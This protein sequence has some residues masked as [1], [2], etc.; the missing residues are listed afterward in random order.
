MN[1]RIGIA[2]SGGGHRATA[3]CLGSLMYLVDSRQNKYVQTIASVSGGSITNAYIALLN[4]PFDKLTKSDFRRYSASFAC[5]IAGSPALWYM[6]IVLV[7]LGFLVWLLPIAPWIRL[8]VSLAIATFSTLV[9]PKS[10]GTFWGW[11]GTWLYV[12]LLTFNVGVLASCIFSLIPGFAQLWYEPLPRLSVLLLIPIFF[13]TFSRRHLI[14][15]LA[16]GSTLRGP[17]STADIRLDK[18]P[19]GDVQHIYCATVLTPGRHFYFSRDFVFAHDYGVGNPAAVRLC[20][21][22]QASSNFPIAFPYRSCKTSIFQFTKCFKQE[23]PKSFLLTDGGVYDNTSTA[24]FLEL[25]NHRIGFRRQAR[26]NRFLDVAKEKLTTEHRAIRKL[27]EEMRTLDEKITALGMQNDKE[28]KAQRAILEMTIATKNAFLPIKEYELCEFTA[29]QAPISLV[30][31]EDIIGKMVPPDQLLAVNAAYPQPWKQ[32]G[33]GLLNIVN[34]FYNTANLQRFK[35]LRRNFL[36]GKLT[37]AFVSIEEAPHNLAHYLANPKKW[38]PDYDS[39]RE[40]LSIWSSKDDVGL[41]EARA[42]YADI[43]D[44]IRIKYVS[45]KELSTDFSKRAEMALEFMVPGVKEHVRKC[46]ECSV[47]IDEKFEEAKRLK[48]GMDQTE[49]SQFLEGSSITS[50]EERKRKVDAIVGEIHELEN[51]R[52]SHDLATSNKLEAFKEFFISERNTNVPT[53]FMPLGR[54]ATAELMR[55][56][57]LNTMMLL[58]ILTG[59]HPLIVAPTSDQFEELASGKDL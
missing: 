30:T 9:G 49:A 48:K 43:F 56:G 16:F 2:L 34:V 19:P 11:W 38:L 24:W 22:V 52:E 18:C 41:L 31:L 47:K 3:F 37:G 32:G 15:G 20:D 7:F 59:D 45:E 39:E 13:L 23:L 55:H 54:K 58:H 21:A 50:Y 1:K 53:T 40:D 44:G 8:L 4:K 5:Q 12:N 26:Y 46:R 35:N 10:K 36:T 14:A 27:Q 25:E 17:S 57:Y 6:T 42:R 29:K 51:E 33:F 28:L